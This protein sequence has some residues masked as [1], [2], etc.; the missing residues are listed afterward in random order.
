MVQESIQCI[1][2]S[3]TYAKE[4]N[5]GFVRHLWFLFTRWCQLEIILIPALC[6]R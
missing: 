1:I 6:E 3:V 2:I 4:T 5:V